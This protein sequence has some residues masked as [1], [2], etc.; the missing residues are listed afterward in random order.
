MPAGLCLK[1]Y[2]YSSIAFCGEYGS[3]GGWIC[4]LKEATSCLSVVGCWLPWRAASLGCSS[5]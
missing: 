3:L 4:D 2:Y 1:S 5:F